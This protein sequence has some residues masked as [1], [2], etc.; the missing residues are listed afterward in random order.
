MIIKILGNLLQTETEF[1]YQKWN[2]MKWNEM[3][4]KMC[5]NIFTAFKPGG[6]IFNENS[7]SLKLST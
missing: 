5:V 2:E 4:W 1:C 3:K 6:I 7:K